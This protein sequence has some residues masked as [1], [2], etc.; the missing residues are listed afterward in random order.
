MPEYEDFQEIAHCGGRATFDISC[1]AD[2]N[3]SFALGF[4]HDRPTPAAWVGIYARALDATPVADFRMGGIGQGFDPP[5]PAGCFPVFL[6]SDSLQCWGHRCPRCQG[7]FRNRIHPAVYPLTCPYC[8]LRTAAHHF[9]TPAQRAYVRH[10]INTLLEGLEAEM[11]PGT[12]RQFVIN[13]DA[14]ADQGADQPKPDFYYTAETQQTRY[15]CD[16]CG[17]FNDIRGRYGYCASCGWRN[18]AQSLQSTFAAL[19]DKLNRGQTSPV[20]AVKS[21]VSEFDACCRDF[22]VQI[23]NRIPMKPGRKAEFERLV[24]HDL[25][26]M[27]VASLKAMFDIDLLRGMHEGIPHLRKMMHRRHLYEHNAG[28]ADE[29]YVRESGDPEAREG[30]LIRETQANAHQLIALLNRA[31]ENLDKDFHE[32][33]PPEQWPVDYQQRRNALRHT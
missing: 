9:L 24:F 8:S 25:D 30:V 27:S 33:Y 17:D 3:R 21:A 31:V 16:H 10:Y 11:E 2:G 20:D 29:R 12:A 26:S 23:K 18:N 5:M 13:M 32:I 6:G 14:I 4:T 22:A 7:Y 19:R 28:V 15:K 1:D